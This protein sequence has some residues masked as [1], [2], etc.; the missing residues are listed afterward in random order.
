MTAS[1]DEFLKTDEKE[2]H[3]NCLD[4]YRL[5]LKAKNSNRYK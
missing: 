5:I 4:D 3:E 2:I 1:I